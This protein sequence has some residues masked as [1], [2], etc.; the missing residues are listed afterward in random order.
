MLKLFLILTL[1]LSQ[2]N[3]FGGTVGNWENGGFNKCNFDYECK[4]NEY[5]V[6]DP[7]DRS[8]QYYHG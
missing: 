3:A 6:V 2:T 8:L 4:P 1:A 5:C 7:N